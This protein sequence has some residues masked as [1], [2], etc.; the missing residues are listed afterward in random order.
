MSVAERLVCRVNYLLSRKFLQNIRMICFRQLVSISNNSLG[1]GDQVKDEHAL[2]PGIES[3]T[4]KGT[5]I[6]NVFLRIL[7]QMHRI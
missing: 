6:R 2:N 4:L 7:N 1:P 5:A 3:L